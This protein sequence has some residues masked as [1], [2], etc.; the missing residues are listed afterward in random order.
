LTVW[1]SALHKTGRAVSDFCMGVRL[2]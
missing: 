1:L 2:E